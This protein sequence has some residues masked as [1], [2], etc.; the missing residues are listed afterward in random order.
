MVV[1]ALQVLGG[2]GDQAQRCGNDHQ[3]NDDVESTA[4]EEAD[5]EH[6]A[7]H[8]LRQAGDDRSDQAGEGNSADATQV[9]LGGVT[10]D[11]QYAEAECSRQE[12]FE[13]G[14]AGVARG[15]HQL[16]GADAA[17]GKGHDV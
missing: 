8:H 4:L 6:G 15:V 10:H 9:T 1:Q 7:Q 16:L 5:V 11:R 12:G 17:H 13:H 2:K 14:R 3:R